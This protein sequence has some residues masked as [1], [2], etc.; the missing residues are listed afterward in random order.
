MIF[1]VLKWS[2]HDLI[3]VGR[4]LRFTLCLFL[5]LRRNRQTS[6]LEKG[7]CGSRSRGKDVNRKQT[8]LSHPSPKM[9][10][11][12]WHLGSSP[13]LK[14][15]FSK[16]CSW[17]C[18]Y[19]QSSFFHTYDTALKRYVKCRLL[20][21]IC[22]RKLKIR[23]ATNQR[24]TRIFVKLCHRGWTCWCLSPDLVFSLKSSCPCTWPVAAPLVL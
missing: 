19:K 3:I 5:W 13:A 24:T 9:S 6:S 14:F 17:Y 18:T 21:V 15:D 22:A 20:L 23:P 4:T 8:W 16:L 10:L 2:N 7:G 12:L 1:S 11:L